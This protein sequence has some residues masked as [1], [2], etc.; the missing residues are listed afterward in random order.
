MRK[1]I[2]NKDRKEMFEFDDTAPFSYH[3]A[4]RLRN[5]GKPEYKQWL[6]EEKIEVI[7]TK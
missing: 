1:I 7:E 3:Y 6:P 4:I 2:I 5:K